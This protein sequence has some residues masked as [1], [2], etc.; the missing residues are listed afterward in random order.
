MS[1]FT[2]KMPVSNDTYFSNT[3]K[4]YFV[5]Y[6]LYHECQRTFFFIILFLILN[7]LTIQLVMAL[8]T[9]MNIANIIILVKDD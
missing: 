1:F 7:S 6:F 2:L 8:C 5:V 9:A 4:F 3:T